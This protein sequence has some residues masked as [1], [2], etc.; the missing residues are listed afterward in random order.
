M[1]KIK[2]RLTSEHPEESAKVIVET[3]DGVYYLDIISDH[4]EAWSDQIIRWAYV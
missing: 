2:W 3:L 1:T 4:F